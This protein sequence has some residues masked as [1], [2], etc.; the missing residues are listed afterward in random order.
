MGRKLR[1]LCQ[2]L[3]GPVRPPEDGCVS[4]SWRSVAYRRG[5]AVMPI[6]PACSAG[7]IGLSPPDIAITLE[8][9][10]DSVAVSAIGTHVARDPSVAALAPTPVSTLAP[11]GHA[12][13]R[14]HVDVVL[15]MRHA[16]TRRLRLSY[17]LAGPDGAPVVLVSGGISA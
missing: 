16:G 7:S 11:A 17:E 10:V 14:G 15:P 5:S 2:V 3:R 9:R 8:V 1:P 4:P 6:L 12:V 13:V